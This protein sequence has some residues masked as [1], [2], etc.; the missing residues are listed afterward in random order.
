[1]VL[2]RWRLVADQ[3]LT[4]HQPVDNLFFL[5]ADDWP[6]EGGKKLVCHSNQ[7]KQTQLDPLVSFS[8][9]WSSW[10]LFD[11]CGRIGWV[12]SGTILNELIICFT[13]D[14]KS[15]ISSWIVPLTAVH[16]GHTFLLISWK[17]L[18]FFCWCLTATSKKDGRNCLDVFNSCLSF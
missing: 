17:W 1:M 4:S 9:F 6:A 15:L 18:S 3:F 2:D 16:N 13:G 8:L 11:A 10:C 7:S 5:S 12:T 14:L